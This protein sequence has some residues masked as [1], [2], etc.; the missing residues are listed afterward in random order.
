I[1][2][3]KTVTPVDNGKTQLVTI[4]ALQGTT[5]IFCALFAQVRI[6]K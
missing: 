3:H 1:E 6:Y 4:S 2:R 5:S